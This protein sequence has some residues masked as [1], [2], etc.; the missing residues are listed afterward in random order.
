MVLF[1]YWFILV[2][3]QNIRSG[4]NRSGMDVIIKVSLLLFLVCCY[5]FK[6]HKVNRNALLI[7]YI[8][9]FC[10]LVTFLRISQDL[11]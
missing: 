7:S 6:S 4:D 1:V 9:F 2:I 3:W 10:Y 5:L 11:I 8:W